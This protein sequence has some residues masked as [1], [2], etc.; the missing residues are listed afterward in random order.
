MSL[1]ETNTTVECSVCND[2][3]MVFEMRDGDWV[4][5]PCRCRE[6]KKIRRMIKS[7]GLSES[8]LKL[9]LS[10]F[11]PSVLTMP[12]YKM[13]KQYLKEYPELF[14][15]TAVSKGF[16]LTG[17]V[18]IGKTMLA[19]IVANELL[20]RHIPTVFVVTPNLMA[21]LK[22]A[23][24]NDYGSDLEEKIHKLSTVQVCVFDD[25]GKEKPTEWV[26][27]QY[28]RI[29]DNRY[30][31]MMPTIFTSNYS[32]NEISERLGDAVASRL[33]SLTKGRQVFVEAPDYRIAGGD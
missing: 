9:K 16:A 28:F 7:S 30:R 29:V 10:D 25:V 6:Q 13:V 19:T 24:F 5:I 3:E 33:Y 17:S 26:Q 8:Q 4:A 23:Q 14:Q 21:E 12:M 22:V 27:T 32:F 20:S 11:K 31:N 18:G 1:T 2:R 15:Q